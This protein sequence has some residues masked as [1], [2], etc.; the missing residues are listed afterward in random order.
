MTAVPS[1][2]IRAANDR[3]IDDGGEFVLY[4]MIAYRRVRWNFALDHALERARELGK[5]LWVFEPLRVG[6]RWASDRFHR[7]VLEGMAANQAALRETPIG[8][9]PYLEPRPGAGSG[10]LERLARSAA[11]VVTDDFPTFFLP[12]MVQAAADRVPVRLEAVDSNGL[13]PMAAAGRPFHRAFDFRRFAQRELPRHL[14]T[15]PVADPTRDCELP[16]ARPLPEEVLQRWPAAEVADRLAT[17]GLADL[18]IDHSVEPVATRGGAIHATAALERFVARHLLRYDRQQNDPSASAHSELSAYLHFGHVSAHEVFDRVTSAVSWDESA[19]AEGATGKRSGWWGAPSA[20]EAFLDQ[21]V[22]WREL[23]YGFCHYRPDHAEYGSLPDWARAT[24][25]EHRHDP[26]PSVYDAS[27]FEA[28]QTHDDLWNAAQTELVRYGRIHN[29]LRMLWGKKVLHWSR[30]PEEAWETL[31]HLNN[32]YALDGRNPN[33]YSG[34]GWV[35]G[36]FDRAWGPERPVFGKVRYMTS[37]NTRR[38]LRVDSYIEQ[39]EM[40]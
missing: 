8:Y 18:P 29:Y 10:L 6:Y 36:R 22:T 40:S 34:I 15:R 12:R 4:W 14:G 33:S 26:R 19:V 3:P 11:L 1:T 13:L 32:K 38:K 2:R 17:G 7:F 28:A 20:V 35:F 5:P 9:L 27:T 24:L 31:V 23:G 21:L 30:S 16:P 39:L 37:S 25:A